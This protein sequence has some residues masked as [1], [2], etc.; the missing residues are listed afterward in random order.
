MTIRGTLKKVVK[1]FSLEVLA[2]WFAFWDRC[3]PWHVK[4]ILLFCIAYVVSPYDLIKDT[5][6]FWGQLDDI[7]VL[8]IGY[9]I[10]RKIIDPVILDDCRERATRFLDAGM[11]NKLRFVT[12]LILLWGFTLFFFAKYLVYKISVASRFFAQR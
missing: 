11:A 10:S 8:R 5:V 1:S 2:M 4:L 6:P 3:V 12:A 9:V 7:V